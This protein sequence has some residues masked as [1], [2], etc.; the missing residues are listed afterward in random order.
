MTFPLV[1]LHFKIEII[2]LSKYIIGHSYYE[3]GFKMSLVY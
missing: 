1:G 3:K 2:I